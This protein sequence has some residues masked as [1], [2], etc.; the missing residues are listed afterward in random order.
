MLR[1]YVVE[2]R[3]SEITHLI[4]L[5]GCLAIALTCSYD[6]LIHPYGTRFMKDMVETN[7][8]DGLNC[9]PRFTFFISQFYTNP[10][11]VQTLHFMG[12]E[13]G[14]RTIDG[15]ILESRSVQDW[16]KQVQAGYFW[17]E[18]LVAGLQRKDVH[19]FRAPN[20]QYTERLFTALRRQN[21]SYD[22]S[23]V[24]KAGRCTGSDDREQQIVVYAWI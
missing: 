16:A 15:N 19:G 23:F 8:R 14:L 10:H 2:F 24:P 6:V 21:V 22:S 4:G 17:M 18:R 13:I 7:V 12:Q 11:K 20:L 3:S 1:Y 5:S 9:R